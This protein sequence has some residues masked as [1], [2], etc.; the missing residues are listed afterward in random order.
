MN[1]CDIAPYGKDGTIMKFVRLKDLD[2]Q[3]QVESDDAV[4]EIPPR[5]AGRREGSRRDE[6]SFRV[7]DSKGHITE[8]GFYY[9]TKPF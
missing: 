5:P 3:F 7:R 4:Y 1:G 2:G 6:M 8:G 9:D